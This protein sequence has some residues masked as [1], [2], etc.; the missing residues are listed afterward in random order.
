M[1]ECRTYTYSELSGLFRT[2]DTQA[3]KRKLDRWDIQYTA[4]GRRALQTFEIEKIRNPFKVYCLLDL[5]SSPQTDFTTLAFFTYNLLC[6][7]E[8]QQLPATIMEER[9]RMD[10]HT[11]SRQTIKTYLSRFEDADLICR[12]LH[13]V[14]Y[15]AYGQTHID[16]DEATYKRAWAEYWDMIRDGYTSD[17]AR[18]AMCSKY[19]G[20]ARKHPTVT[21]NAF[22]NP[23]YPSLVEWA[24][25]IMEA[26]M[27]KSD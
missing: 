27:G 11:L 15:F 7:D 14:Y 20:V 18:I 13:Y 6:D 4:K 23:V 16:T 10:G 9:L 21:L 1:L 5:G 24:G 17:S 8:F 12:G 25:Q 26:N 2:R 19:G 22:Y 3:I